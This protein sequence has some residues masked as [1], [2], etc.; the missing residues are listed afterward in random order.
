MDDLT[1]PSVIPDLTG[2]GEK[3]L[4]QLSSMTVALFTLDSVVHE[5]FQK[6]SRKVEVEYG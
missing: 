5:E 6:I 3:D 4:L 2:F 1:T